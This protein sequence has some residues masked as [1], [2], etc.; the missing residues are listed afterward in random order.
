MGQN[1]K[2]IILVV[3]IFL[4]LVVLNLFFVA[5][6]EGANENEF[7]GNRS[8]FA[9]TP[10]GTLAYYRLLENSGF[11]VTRLTRAFTSLA[12]DGEI[13]AL[14][15]VPNTISEEPDKEEMDALYKWVETGRLL[16]VIDRAISFDLPGN[17]SAR[18]KAGSY[19]AVVKPIQPTPFTRSV[20]RV[21]VTQYASRVTVASDSVTEH[22]G[23]AAGSLLSDVVVGKGRVVFLTEPYIV[24]NNGIG[25]F[26]NVAV[27]LNLVSLK[28]AGKVA[29]DEYHHGYDSSGMGAESGMLAYFKGTPVPWLLAQAGLIVLVLV[30]TQG[31]RFGRPLPLRRERRTTNLEFVAS[32]A[33]ITRIARATDL[34]MQNVYGEFRRRLCRYSGLPPR[35]DSAR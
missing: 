15:Y 12:S 35:A 16:V 34:A 4:L 26:D 20:Q 32:M 27:A 2:G 19:S 21:E 18:S 33:T 29:F 31:R 13:G 14:I 22:M 8:S 10:Y 1:S 6:N 24:A 9:S 3:G 28:P 23:D 30:Y 25:E 7:S 11:K 5:G 17:V